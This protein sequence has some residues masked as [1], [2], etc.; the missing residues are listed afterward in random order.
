MKKPIY[1]CGNQHAAIFNS[2]IHALDGTG[3]RYFILRNYEGLPEYNESKDIDLIIEPGKYKSAAQLLLNTFRCHGVEYYYVVKYERVRCWFGMNS[4][5]DF[6][7]H[8]DLIEGYV[9]K[10]FEIFEFD[11]LY[12]NTAVYKEYR[13]LNQPYDIA[14]LLLY[15]VIGAKE[16]KQRYRD[17]ISAGYKSCKNEIRDILVEVLGS[18]LAQ[19]VCSKVEADE[20][21]WIVDHS[22]VISRTSKKIAFK[23]HPIST[24]VNVMRF[25]NEKVYRIGICPKKYRKMIALEAPDGTGKTTFIDALTVM[26][27]ETFVC[28]IEKM[29]VY[30]FRP[31][32][33]PNLGA[34]GEK[35]GV[36]KQD[37]NF[38]NPH[39]NK[40]A[41]PL[42]SFV[43]MGYYWLD[44]LIGGA[45]CIRKDV[46]FDK[47]T[48][49]DRYIYDFII[50][51]LRSRINLPRCMRTAFSKMVQQPRIVFVLDAPADVIYSRK[52]EL[53]FDE[54]QRQ[55]EEF[56]KLSNLDDNFYKINAN[57]TP[58]KMVLDA[59]KIILDKFCL[60]IQK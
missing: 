51:P 37:T 17:K 18:D 11:K 44:Y 43:R 56:D 59:K 57:Q 47:I 33:L 46:Q 14:M 30:H 32:V 6:A 24:V 16:L 41:N 15:K 55:L 3:I 52:K 31:S 53:T 26:L 49:F 21:E 13:V 38:E 39:R 48:I 27:A 58:E 23:K 36:M 12:G 34:V 60:K 25:L 22:K 19:K 35:A 50:D 29:H 7:I 9:N 1:D 20:Y 8:I 42:S 40:A 28:D 54:I 4:T 45:I 10:G 2:Y 5:S